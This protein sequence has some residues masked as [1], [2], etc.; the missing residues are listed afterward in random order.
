MDISMFGP[1]I[2]S[3]SFHPLGNGIVNGHITFDGEKPLDVPVVIIGGGPAG[4]L[5]AYLLS[6]LGGSLFR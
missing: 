3:R 5:Q 1:H 4:L 6:K 2:E